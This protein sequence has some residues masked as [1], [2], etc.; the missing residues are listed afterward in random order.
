M[1]ASH[2]VAVESV[3]FCG[4]RLQLN[5]RASSG[6]CGLSGNRTVLYFIGDRHVKLLGEGSGDANVECGH[7]EGAIL[8]NEDY[9]VH[10]NASH[11]IADELIALSGSCGQLNLRAGFS[12]GGFSSNGTVFDFI[13]DGNGVQHGS[14]IL[15]NRPS[16]LVACLL[17]SIA[18]S[19][20]YS[21][22]IIIDTD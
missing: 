4:S 20:G 10:L 3:A 12:A 19:A 13:G 17:V 15:G 14:Y 22:G 18:G 1:I 11:V 6:L 9:L 2:H 8:G 21:F 5:L 7:L 16:A